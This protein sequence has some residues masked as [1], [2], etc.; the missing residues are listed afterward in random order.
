M[1]ITSIWKQTCPIAVKARALNRQHY[2]YNRWKSRLKSTSIELWGVLQT[3]FLMHPT[4]SLDKWKHHCSSVEASNPYRCLYQQFNFKDSVCDGI[5]F[6]FQPQIYFSKIRFE[7][8]NNSDPG[9]DPAG[10]WTWNGRSSIQI[11]ESK[12]STDRY[13]TEPHSY[14]QDFLQRC[15]RMFKSDS[16]VTKTISLE[17]QFWSAHQTLVRMSSMTYL[18]LRK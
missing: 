8:Q 16:T 15:Y 4:A 11:L 10:P 3:W 17:G 7:I 14:T 9:P 18:L 1:S 2:V 12:N 5:C 13:L 6:S